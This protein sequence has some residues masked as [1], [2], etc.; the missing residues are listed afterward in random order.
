M[1]DLVTGK[2]SHIPAQPGV[3]LLIST[4]LQVALAAAALVPLLFMT[5]ALPQPPVMMAFVAAPPAP[6]PPPP[7][8]PP[9]A[10]AAKKE[11]PATRPVPAR[12]PDAAPIEVPRELPPPAVQASIDE[13]IEG[14]V[15]GGIPGGVLGGVVGG[16]PDIPLPPPPP[17]PQ[18]VRRDPVRIGGQ[19]KQPALLRRVEPMYPAMAVQAH[20]EGVVILE[21]IVD[22]EG[23]VEEV[24]VL[25]SAGALLDH[26]ALAAVRQWQYSPVLLNGI[27]ERFVLTVVLSFNLEDESE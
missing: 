20:L 12:A 5:G 17:P 6:P 3:P 8:P 10:P 1:F 22:R 14:G 16:I 26:A 19:I 2:A 7:P 9:P 23:L 11:P 25:R 15:E 13:G 27:P 24:K 18:P 4:A 21:A